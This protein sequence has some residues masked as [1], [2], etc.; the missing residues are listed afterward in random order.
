AKE[1]AKKGR[2]DNHFTDE[3]S[4]E[5]DRDASNKIEAVREYLKRDEDKV[6]WNTIVEVLQK[7]LE[8]PRDTFIEVDNVDPKTGAKSKGRV[9]IRVEV[10]RIIGTFP[11]QGRQFYQ[12]AYGQE[13][14][15]KLKKAIE[16]ND[17][18]LLAEVADR[19]L[20]TKA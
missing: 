6:P 19:Y 17:K 1:N 20:H 12:L 15:A 14:D 2:L 4:L 7:L 3:F 9:S 5:I 8:S 18:H 16:E 13:A 10:N 11:P